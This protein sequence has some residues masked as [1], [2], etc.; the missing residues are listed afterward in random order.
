MT[1]VLGLCPRYQ[2]NDI[3]AFRSRT[4]SLSL[5]ET[6]VMK[7]SSSDVPTMGVPH[8]RW[9]LVA[10]LVF[11]L[12]LLPVARLSAQNLS[13]VDERKLLK[14]VAP[15]YPEIAKGL[16]LNGVV[17]VALTVAPNG[18]IKSVE[19]I[20]GHPLLARAAVDAVRQWRYETGSQQTTEVVVVQFNP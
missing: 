1:N 2:G 20:G 8:L 5:V 15:I 12:F 3:V 7:A 10:A 17:K 13:T 9:V 18:A 6:E 4:S 19:V 11:Q 16:K 14:K